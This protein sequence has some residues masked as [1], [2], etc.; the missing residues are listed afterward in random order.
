MFRQG[1][2]ESLEK[3]KPPGGIRM[4]RHRVPG[5]ARAEALSHVEKASSREGLVFFLPGL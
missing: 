5:I 3:E 2:G 1:R 4:G